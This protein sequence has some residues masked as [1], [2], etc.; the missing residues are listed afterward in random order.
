MSDEFDRLFRQLLNG[1]KT[2]EKRHRAA[3]GRASDNNE[4]DV[5]DHESAIA[6]RIT[7]WR[8]AL[9]ALRVEI[10]DSDAVVDFDTV[11]EDDASVE[12]TLTP[13]Q[14]AE[15]TIVVPDKSKEADEADE[16]DETDN[17]PELAAESEMR[18]PF[19]DQQ[20]KKS[21]EAKPTKQEPITLK[22]LGKQYSVNAWDDLYV[23]V[24]ESLL[25]HR[26]YSVAMLNKNNEFNSETQT[27]FSYIKSEIKSNQTRLPNGLWF[28]KIKDPVD[29]MRNCRRLL[30]TCGF[31]SDELIIETI[32][33]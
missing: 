1:L 15:A 18:A 28:E 23:K 26:P 29:V 13:L 12:V 20:S 19:E 7:N 8:R 31:S 16:A 17:K 3:Y 24:C 33:G 25:L 30:E 2:A 14:I 10:V 27:R 21:M 6:L 5:A 9:E 32:G 11:S 22:L 4:W